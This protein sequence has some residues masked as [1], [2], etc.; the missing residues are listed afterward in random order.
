MFTA[1]ALGLTPGK[2][3]IKLATADTGDRILDSAVFIKASSFS[4]K[5]TDPGKQVPEP[6]SVISLLALG[7]IGM[8]SVL[9]SQKKQL[10]EKSSLN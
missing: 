10:E 4:D 5:P 1:K 8:G 3:K 2:H 9:K 7:A 6:A